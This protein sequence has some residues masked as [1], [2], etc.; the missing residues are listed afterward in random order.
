MGSWYASKKKAFTKHSANFDANKEQPNKLKLGMK[1]AH[2]CEVQINGGSVA[3]KVKFATWVLEQNVT[4]ENVFKENERC[5]A[6][7][8][9]KGHGTEGVTHR[10]GVSRLPRKSH[11]G[12]R[13]VACI[14]AWHPSRVSYSVARA[15]QNGFHHR[16][17]INKKIYRIGKG[18]D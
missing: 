17:E 10:W 18:D 4:V 15:G 3:D 2:V 7:G 16:T 14:G 5:D 8:V 13:K 6:I 1:K 11:R 12:L 9:T